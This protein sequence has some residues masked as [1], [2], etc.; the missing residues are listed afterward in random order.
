MNE[1]EFRYM[2]DNDAE[3]VNSLRQQVTKLHMELCS[4]FFRTDTWT[5]IKDNILNISDD[6]DKKIII[7]VLDGNVIGYAMIKYMMRPMKLYAKETRFLYIEEI[8]IDNNYRG[9]GY[10]T[11][12]ME[13]LIEEARKNGCCKFELGVW[14]YNINAVT[15][16]EKFGFKPYKTMME[17][18]FNA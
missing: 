4:D 3:I 15:F 12:L 7:E 6:K 8:G 16:Y 14:N 11:R 9:K 10:G 17:Y 2:D 18:F 5:N 13:F 1:V